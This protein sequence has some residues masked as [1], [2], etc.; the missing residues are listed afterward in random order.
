MPRLKPKQHKPNWH[1]KLDAVLCG[2]CP[3]YDDWLR[4]RQELLKREV[5]HGPKIRLRRYQTTRS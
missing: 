4:K 5:Q 1:E 2:L 3:E